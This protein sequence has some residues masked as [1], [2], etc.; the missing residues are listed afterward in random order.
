MRLNPVKAHSALSV[1]FVLA[2]AAT[3]L[4]PRE[5]GATETQCGQPEGIDVRVIPVHGEI[6]YDFSKS[7]LDIQRQ[8]GPVAAA[9]HY[10]LLG[11]AVQGFGIVTAVEAN[12]IVSSDGRVCP[13][14]KAVE[15]RIG[16]VDRTIFIATEVTSA[17]C[18]HAQTLEHQL[19][20]V[21]LEDEALAAF[22]PGFTQELRGAVAQL[23]VEPQRDAARA[24]RQVRDAVDAI[25][26]GLLG[27]LENER[28]WRR[29][30]VESREEL[31]RMRQACPDID[32]Q[33]REMG[34]PL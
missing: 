15:I 14:L 9:R 29:E 12:P 22:M 33:I 8:A 28:R 6:K 23:S 16:W 20:H 7:F 27:P 5:A 25:V 10:P 17:E 32:Q 2:L 18:L 26:G 34:K 21:R 31:D 30:I 4:L 13:V 3:V 1:F 11:M 19:R 24:D